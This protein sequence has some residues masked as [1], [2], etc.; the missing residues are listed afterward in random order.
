MKISFESGDFLLI[1]HSLTMV[2][3]IRALGCKWIFIFCF[4]FVINLVFLTK[5]MMIIKCSV[6][7]NEFIHM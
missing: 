7:C 1:F 5:T 6:M 2:N 4:H 3:T